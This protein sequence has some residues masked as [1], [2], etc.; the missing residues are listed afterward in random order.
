MKTRV[1]SLAAAALAAAACAG[2]AP[3]PEPRTLAAYRD[4]QTPPVYALLGEREELA[5]S[6]GQVNTIDSIAEALRER[7]RPLADQLRGMTGSG[8]GGPV[9]RPRSAEE[10]A[11]FLPVL[12]EIGR[13][14][15]EAMD[16]VGRALSDEQRGKVCQ[17]RPERAREHPPFATPAG[18][19]MPG[20][21][22]HAR[23][24][25]M[26]MDSATA[27]VLRRGGRWSWCP[28]PAPAQART[29]AARR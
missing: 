29:E 18:R 28:P 3:R 23:P 15:R 12:E 21:V 16:A 26:P 10:E 8:A 9:R 5:L 13:N 19:D 4:A 7:N 14:N 22:R 2:T 25:G 6:S 11:R 1:L 27:D 17:M 20:R 24:R